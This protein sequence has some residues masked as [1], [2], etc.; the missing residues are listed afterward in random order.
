M[1][2]RY[3]RGWTTLKNADAYEN[4]LK[5]KILPGLKNIPGYRGEYV[6]RR[7]VPDEVEFVVINLFDSIEAVQAFAADDY[8]AAK[9]NCRP[10]SSPRP[11]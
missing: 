11:F 8:S 2:A 3:W 7:N 5:E 9:S 4:H 1:I 10:C 6:L